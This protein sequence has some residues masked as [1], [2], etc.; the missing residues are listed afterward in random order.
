MTGCVPTR[1]AGVDR[2]VA[3]NEKAE[4][5]FLWHGAADN[6][7]VTHGIDVG[8]NA[9]IVQDE[10]F[11]FKG[12]VDCVGL[13]EEPQVVFGEFEIRSRV[14]LSVRDRRRDGADNARK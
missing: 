5:D 1:G 4:R 14:L 9:G 10:T 13:V 8:L 3:Q 6:H 12:A 11:G 7:A 2:G